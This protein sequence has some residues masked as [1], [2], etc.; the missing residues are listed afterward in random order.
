MSMLS[1]Q[2]IGIT[3]SKLAR[4]YATIAH[5]RQPPSRSCASL[6]G[7]SSRKDF[8]LQDF[9]HAGRKENRLRAG[10]FEVARQSFGRPQF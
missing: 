8:H 5:L 10:F 4:L 6:K 9:A 2:A 1:K 7:V 3:R